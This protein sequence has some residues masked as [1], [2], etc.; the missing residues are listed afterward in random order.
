[1]VAIMVGSRDHRTQ[2]WKG[3]ELS[4]NFN[5]SYM[6]GNSLTYIPNFSEKYFFQ[7]I[8]QIRHIIIK[9]PILNLLL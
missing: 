4:S 7:P 6:A 2:L 8:M 9:D 5:C 3:A 1:L